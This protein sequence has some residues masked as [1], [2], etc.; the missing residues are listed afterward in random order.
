MPVSIKIKR[1]TTASDVPTTSELTDGEIAV[2]VADKKIYVRDGS[3]I[4][5]VANLSSGGSVDLSAVAQNIIPDA[6]GTRNLGSATK[7]FAELFLAGET[8]N[9]GGATISSDGTG[10][11]S[12]S[13]T[14]VTL[15][16]ESKDEDGN[17]LAVQ[18]TGGRQVIRKVP[19]FSAAGGLSTVNK[20][21]EF[22]AT[23]DN[24]TAFG[25]A[26]TFTLSDGS[27]LTDTDPTLFQF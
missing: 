16:A 14:G 20:N 19:F 12:V 4:V 27:T 25:E 26:H 18:G 21:F 6:N 7:R 24:K 1:F 22:N 11:V 8:I 5:E 15:P 23:I 2:N 9:L 10:T 17:K 3:S 13:A